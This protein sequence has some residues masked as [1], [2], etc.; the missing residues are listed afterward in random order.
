MDGWKLHLQQHQAGIQLPEKAVPDADPGPD[1][2]AP[3]GTGGPHMND[4][5]GERGE[6]AAPGQLGR[7]RRQAR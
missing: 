1:W 5:D 3:D 2:G 7:R 4:G 6:R